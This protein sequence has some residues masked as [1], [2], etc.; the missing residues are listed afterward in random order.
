MRKIS[1]I[2]GDVHLLT[3][4]QKSQ[5]FKGKWFLLAGK[6][7]VID[8]IGGETPE[9]EDADGRVPLL[10]KGPRMTWVPSKNKMGIGVWNARLKKYVGD[11]DTITEPI[12]T[13]NPDGERVIKCFCVTG[14]RITCL[15]CGHQFPS[16]NQ[17]KLYCSPECKN[18]AFIE[19]RRNEIIRKEGY[20]STKKGKKCP[21]CDERYTPKTIKSPTC[22]KSRCR[23]AWSR[24]QKQEKIKHSSSR[25]SP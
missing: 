22:G 25:Q 5:T 19:K 9:I 20:P 1:G 21:I 4:L 8:F 3:E 15:Y 2:R 23:T 6:K 7:T 13:I 24:I 10:K 14:Y 11:V 18:E 12:Y 17:K 16:K